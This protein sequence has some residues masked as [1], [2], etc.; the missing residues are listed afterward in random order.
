MTYL[1]LISCVQQP[2]D[3]WKTAFQSPSPQPITPPPQQRSNLLNNLAQP[4]LPLNVQNNFFASNPLFN[5]NPPLSQPNLLTNPYTPLT[6]PM[7][8]NT[9]SSTTN[10]LNNNTSNNN[11]ADSNH[12]QHPSSTTNSNYPNNLTISLANLQNKRSFNPYSQQNMLIGEFSEEFI[13]EMQK[14][15]DNTDKKYA[16]LPKPNRPCW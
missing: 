7:S 8:N 6:N 4:G 10:T 14:A 16:N 1:I 5:P 11:S 12:L 3:P 13:R 2:F 9:P 15:R